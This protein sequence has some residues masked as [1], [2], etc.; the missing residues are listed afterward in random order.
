VDADRRALDARVNEIGDLHRAIVGDLRNI[1]FKPE[2]FD[3]VYC[4]EVLEHIRGAKEV[5]KAFFTWLQPNGVALLVFPD[6]DTLFGLATRFSPHWIHV[7]YHKY[8]LGFPD[9]GK[10]GFGPYRTYYD[11]IISRRGI[12]KFCA[13]HNYHIALEYGRPPAL[14]SW[15]RWFSSIYKVIGPII[16]RLSCGAISSNHIGLIYVIEK[17]HHS[18]NRL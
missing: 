16:S 3:V 13:E 1:N 12:H 9:A 15:A 18:G 10:A 4:C 14:G 5:L 7:A 17:K 2:E 6:R 8:V 11:D